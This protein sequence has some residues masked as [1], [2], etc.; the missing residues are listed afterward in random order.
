M[1]K[2]DWNNGTSLNRRRRSVFVAKHASQL[3][4][5]AAALR[6]PS[7][8]T[9]ISFSVTK[10]ICQF[11]IVAL[12]RLRRSAELAARVP[13]VSDTILRGIAEFDKALPNLRK[14][15]NVG[16]HIDDYALD[17]KR[18]HH[19]DIDRRQ[20]QVSSWDGTIFVW[21]NAALNV[22]DALSAAQELFLTVRNAAADFQQTPE[23]E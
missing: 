8:M 7:R 19:P 1:T 23:P 3:R 4:C 18:R 17:S 14:M 12:R 15:R 13:A 11:F 21:L 10:L 6:H 5:N 2:E 20:L 16:E 22:D 9:R